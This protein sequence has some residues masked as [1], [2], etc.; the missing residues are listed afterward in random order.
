MTSVFAFSVAV[1]LALVQ[2]RVAQRVSSLVILHGWSPA[3]GISALTLLRVPLALLVVLVIRGWG[4]E[5]GMM[6]LLGY[7]LG[8]MQTLYVSAR[9]GTG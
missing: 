6:G 9:R 5:V 4:L 8:F 2:L 1:L 7:H 3:T